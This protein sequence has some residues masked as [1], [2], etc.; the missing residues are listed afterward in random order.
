M[1]INVCGK[2][3]FR[4]QNKLQACILRGTVKQVYKCAYK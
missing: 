1:L 3:L 4:L 2:Y